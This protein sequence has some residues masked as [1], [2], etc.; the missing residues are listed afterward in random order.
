[1]PGSTRLP[2]K[3]SANDALRQ[4]ALSR[5]ISFAVSRE[6]ATSLG[7]ATGVGATLE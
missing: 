2:E 1:M 5:P 6:K 3:T 4:S 7:A